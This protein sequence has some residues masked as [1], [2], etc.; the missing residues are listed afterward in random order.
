MNR[1]TVIVGRNRSATVNLPNTPSGGAR[2]L[3]EKIS[4]KVGGVVEF[5]VE[6]L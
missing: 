2:T 3:R 4:N 6:S 1:P 5:W